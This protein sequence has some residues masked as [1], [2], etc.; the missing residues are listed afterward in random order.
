MPK[1]LRGISK[2]DV[3]A[4]AAVVVVADATLL[5]S[6][7]FSRSLSASPPALFAVLVTSSICRQRP[8]TPSH[9]T[10]SVSSSISL[11]LFET[12]ASR[13]HAV[14]CIETTP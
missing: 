8:E 6:V 10:I 4:M 14:Q 9:D 7:C 12:I 13:R 2:D 1:A 3:V 5:L 11:A